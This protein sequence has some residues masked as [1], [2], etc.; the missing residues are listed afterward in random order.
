MDSK[1]P[2][3]KEGTAWISQIP[4]LVGTPLKTT[5]SIEE[6]NYILEEKTYPSKHEMIFQLAILVYRTVRGYEVALS[7]SYKWG[8]VTPVK[9]IYFRPFIGAPFHPICNW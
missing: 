1:P 8:E 4:G 7:P 3:K 9:P 5:M 6:N 2:H